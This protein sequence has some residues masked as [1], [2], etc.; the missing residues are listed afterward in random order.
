MNISKARLLLYLLLPFICFLPTVTANASKATFHPTKAHCILQKEIEHIDVN[1]DGTYT[2]TDEIFISILDEKGKRQQQV[3]S[4]FLNKNYSTFEMELLEIIRPDGTKINIDWKANSRETNPAQTTRMN[5][6]DPNQKVIKIFIPGL[7]V[8]DV[9]HYRIKTVA[10]KPMIEE[11]FFGNAVLQHSFPLKTAHL[12]ID[13]PENLPLY[14]LIKDRPAGSDV[15]FSKYRKGGKN[16]YQWK[17]QDIK[18]MVPEPNMPELSRVA[19]R[20]LFSTMK[21]WREVSRW[22]YNLAEP[23]LKPTPEIIAKVKE[24]MQGKKDQEEII[25]AIFFFVSRKIRY[26]GLIEEAKRPGFE[27]HDVGLTFSRKYG[28]CRDKAA[29]LVSMLRVAGFRACPVIIKAGGKLDPEIPVPYFNHAIAAIMDEKGQPKIYM[30][31]TSETSTQF[32]PDYEQDSS[33]LPATKEGSELLL[34]P[35]NPPDRNY[36]VMLIKDELDT[37]STLRGSISVQTGNFIDTAFRSILMSRSREH[38]K[39]F[40]ERFIL[41]RRPGLEVT[42]LSWSDPGDMSRPF[43]FS[44]SFSMKNPQK[45]AMLFP[46]SLAQ[47]L[48][49]LDNWII[50]RASMTKRRYPLKL[51]YAI[52]TVIKEETTIHSE[53]KSLLIPETRD[54]SNKYFDFH[55]H[56]TASGKSLKI[57]RQFVNKALEVPPDDYHLL[58]ELQGELLQESFQPIFLKRSG[59]EK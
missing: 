7:R 44:C 3:L 14:H 38:Q 45:D 22:Y 24:L 11:Q 2:D 23:K 25:K 46:P 27:P 35:V 48:G 13:M 47:D 33:C 49:L 16:S 17:I 6:Y 8:D 51:G 40:L 29:L 20:L 18:E 5:I 57:E 37:N 30:D 15:M 9:I 50:Q 39:R 10:F 54:F 32:L 53:K 26:M 28:V 56:I 55:T 42:N 36:F 58:L 52:K 34:T 4:F 41:K 43:H 31:P 12:T 21:S 1:P 59:G 19:T